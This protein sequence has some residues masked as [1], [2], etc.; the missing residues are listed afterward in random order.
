MK[1]SI[2]TNIVDG[3]WGG[4][5]LF[6][7]NLLNYLKEKGHDVVLNLDDDDIDLILMTEP[8]KTSESSAFTHVDILKYISYVNSKTLV[9]H[10]INEC[11]ERKNTNFVNQYLIEA[12]KVADATIFVSTWLKNLFFNQG[13]FSEKN[14]VILSGADKEIFN[15]ESYSK[16]N[17]NSKLRIVTHHWGADWNKGFDIYRQ[18][19]EMIGTEKYKDK[20]EFTYIGN[21]PKKFKFNNSKVI[22]PISGKELSREIQ[23]NHVY[24]TASINEPSGNHHIEGAQCGL[25]ILFINSGGTPEYCNEFGVKFEKEN[26]EV[27][28]DFFIETYSQYVE[29]M[30]NYPN[31]ANLMCK[32]YEELFLSLFDNKEKI[33]EERNIE[34]RLNFF[35]KYPYTYSR[36]IKKYFKS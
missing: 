28:L 1:I 36:K 9:V 25:P 12:N 19:D 15:S 21:L 2:G 7:I 20:I 32:K 29:N 35:E 8:R 16:W 4:G 23:K 22:T 11:D 10:R 3:P 18:L 30:K 17:N 27:K 34:T 6:A 33:I 5:N 14:Q 13:L 31:N 24:L 26:F